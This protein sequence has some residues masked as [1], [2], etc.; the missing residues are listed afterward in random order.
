MIGQGFQRGMYIVCDDCRVGKYCVDL[1]M[2]MNGNLKEAR[3]HY[4]RFR[5]TNY[6]NQIIIECVGERAKK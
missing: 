3:C 4:Y 6:R 1:A 5:W 2:E